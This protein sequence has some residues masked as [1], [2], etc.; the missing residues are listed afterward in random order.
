MTVSFNYLILFTKTVKQGI[1]YEEN[2]FH[3]Q[4]LCMITFDL[5][6]FYHYIAQRLLIIIMK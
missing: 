6:Q 3:Y 4:L 2:K 1:R 5:S